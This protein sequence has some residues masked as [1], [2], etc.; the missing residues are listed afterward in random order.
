MLFKFSD[1][2]GDRCAPRF[3]VLALTNKYFRFFFNMKIKLSHA[4]FV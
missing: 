1:R 4:R 2:R 3:A